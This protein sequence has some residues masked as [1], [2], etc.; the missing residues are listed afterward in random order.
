MRRW[1]ILLLLAMTGAPASAQTLIVSPGAQ[2]R[3]VTVYRDPQ[4]GDGSI[5]ARFPTGF[6]LVTEHRRITLPPGDATIR[7]E[8]VADGMI[9]VSAAVTGLPGGVIQ[10]NR[11][12]RLLSP[13][14]LTLGA[15]GKAVHLRRTDPATGR[16]VEQDAIIRSTP[17]QALVIE[18]ADGVEALR[19]SGLPETLIHDSV[20]SDL[21]VTPTLSID[22]QSDRAT[23]ADVTL[24]YLTTGFDW[25][26]DYVARIA[27]D[28]QT[29]DLFAWLTVAN[30][31]SVAFPDAR[32]LAIAGR[33]NRTSD[34]DALG[35]APDA[36]PLYLSCWPEPSYDGEDDEMGYGMAPP[37]PPPPPPA[38]MAAQEIMVTGRRVATQEELGD[39]KLYRVPMTVDLNP[40]GQKQV[41]LLHQRA[42]AFTTVHT[43]R[44]SAQGEAS[45]GGPLTRTLRFTNRRE[46]GAGVPLPSGGL[47][48]FAMRGEES[49]LLAQARMRD[50]AIGDKVEIAA[51]QSPHLRYERSFDDKT[52]RYGLRLI[53]SGTEPLV[54]EIIVQDDEANRLVGSRPRLVRRDGAWLWTATV[55]AQGTAQLDYRLRTPR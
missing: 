50:Q 27:P 52:Q 22:T 44:L 18:S 46:S 49:L 16:V 45:E 54:A 41:A 15:L 43:A 3:S 24:T 19:C 40:N 34:Y 38:M 6:A 55:P 9:A 28:G 25:A 30:G 26:A 10:K 17:D 29:L 13:A 20:P 53:N 11:D 39:L 47:S 5:N 36:P 7:F 32:L 33:L 8:G 37:P 12:A 51:G 35:R 1:L 4:R 21:S 31:N 42:I 2:S 48:L 23:Q 14:N